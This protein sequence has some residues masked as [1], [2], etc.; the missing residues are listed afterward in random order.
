MAVKIYTQQLETK[1][2]SIVPLATQPFAADEEAATFPPEEVTEVTG[3]GPVG[4]T[5]VKISI[6][7]H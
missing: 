1:I 7:I 6:G 4:K 2:I 5:K 3:S